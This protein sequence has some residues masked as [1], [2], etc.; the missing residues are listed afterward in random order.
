MLV[1]GVRRCHLLRLRDTL[2]PEIK[3]FKANCQT[4]WCSL[5][6]PAVST[7]LKWQRTGCLLLENPCCDVGG[8][9]TR[10]RC[11][12]ATC[13]SFA[14]NKGACRNPSGAYRVLLQSTQTVQCGV[15]CFSIVAVSA[16]VLSLDVER[17]TE[18]RSRE[19]RECCL[20][21]RVDV[22]VVDGEI[23]GKEER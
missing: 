14:S 17:S 15:S 12:T 7:D 10:C 8:V 23:L 3:R 19:E 18:A 1:S 20:I 22:G 16:T 21:V 11:C 2:N 4:N 9:C 5:L 13:Q 6:F